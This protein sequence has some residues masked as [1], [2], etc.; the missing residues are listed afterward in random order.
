MGLREFQQLQSHIQHLEFEVW[1]H[2]NLKVSTL[3][4]KDQFLKKL[5]L[6]SLLTSKMPIV[7]ISNIICNNNGKLNVCYDLYKTKHC[8]SNGSDKLVHG[9]SKERALEYSEEDP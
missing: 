4:L 6:L 5:V 3:T 9:K 7:T 1:E 8:T 2:P